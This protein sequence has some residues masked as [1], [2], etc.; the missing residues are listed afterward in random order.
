MKRK[1]FIRVSASAMLLLANGKIIRANEMTAEALRA[2]TVFRFAVASDGHYGEKGTDYESHFANMVNAVN[3]EHA[4]NPFQ[5]A[6]VNGDI[7]H[8]DKTFYPQAKAALDKF[9]CKYY[10]SQGNHDRLTHEEWEAVWGMP[11]NLDFTHK[12][13]AFL[14]ATTSNAAGE[15]LCPD[16]NWLSS[17]LDEHKKREIFIFLHIN[18]GKLT[19]HGVD[20]PALFEL[21]RGHGNV[22]AIFNGHDHD[23][24]GIKMREN[25]PFVFDAHFGG[26]WGTAYRGYRVVEVM[27]DGS[28]VTYIKTPVDEINRGKL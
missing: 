26:S 4:K 16:L 22:R 28:V 25:V 19:T 6:L 14:I 2:K 20:C 15:Y 9:Q 24:D 10:V 1:D 13:C 21:L 17:K 3:D 5:F 11:V 23:E 8:D 7:V 12:K 27:N 18:P